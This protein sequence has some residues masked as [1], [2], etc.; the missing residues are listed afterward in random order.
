MPL[1]D[2]LDTTVSLEFGPVGHPAL[3]IDNPEKQEN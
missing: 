3:G 2:L 1:I